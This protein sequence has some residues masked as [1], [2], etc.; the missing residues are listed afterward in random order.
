[1]MDF[2]SAHVMQHQA[3][4]PGA[5]QACAQVP[6]AH[7]ELPRS[8]SGARQSLCVSQTLS[9][10]VWTMS[11]VSASD[12]AV[13]RP[14]WPGVGMFSGVPCVCRAWK[15]VRVPPWA[16]QVP[17]SEGIFALTRVQ[18]VYMVSSDAGPGVFGPVGGIPFPQCHPKSRGL[19]DA[20]LRQGRR[21]ADRTSKSLVPCIATHSQQAPLLT[22]LGQWERW[23]NAGAF[24]F[25]KAPKNESMR[26]RRGRPRA[27]D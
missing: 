14:D 20:F 9:E 6:L 24:N 4:K 27:Q 12:W 16:L 25:G 21:P 15:T 22:V 26:V 2:E 5:G 10:R 3:P 18:R 8:W 23:G 7:T 17:S 11:T 13:H 1:M 19:R